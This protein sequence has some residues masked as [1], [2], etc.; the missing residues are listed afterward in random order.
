[1]KSALRSPS[2]YPDWRTFSN[3][4]VGVPSGASS[5]KPSCGALSLRFI[6][7]LKG[8]AG[9]PP[10][11]GGQQVRPPAGP[12]TV[13]SSPRYSAFL[14]KWQERMPRTQRPEFDTL[15]L[16]A[17]RVRCVDHPEFTGWTDG[18]DDRAAA[19]VHELQLRADRPVHA[20]G[21]RRHQARGFFVVYVLGRVGGRWPFPMKHQDT[22][23]PKDGP[24]SALGPVITKT[25]I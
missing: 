21:L 7:W 23:S 15:P 20:P 19:P 1:M 16:C 6:H 3:R 11:R 2:G 22:I 12:L 25:I 8:V 9:K 13:S 10:G 17:G 18:V 4:P 5:L 24:T 14:S